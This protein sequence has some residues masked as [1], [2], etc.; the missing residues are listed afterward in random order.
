MEDFDAKY[1]S[2]ILGDISTVTA[3]LLISDELKKQNKILQELSE[4]IHT[5]RRATCLKFE[6]DATPR[7]PDTP[8]YDEA[9]RMWVHPD[10]RM[11]NGLTARE[12]ALVRANAHR[13]D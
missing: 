13:A 8:R 5:I 6:F 4:N 3:L 10:G 9:L 7:D 2:P 12:A 11:T 1:K